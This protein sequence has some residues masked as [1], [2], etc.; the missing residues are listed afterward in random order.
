NTTGDFVAVLN[1]ATLTAAGTD[2]LIHSSSAAYNVLSGTA[3]TTA[4]RFFFDV[5]GMGGTTGTRPSTATLAGPLL[6]SNNDRF[7][8]AAAFLMTNAGGATPSE[9]VALRQAAGADPFVPFLGF[10]GSV[11]HLGFDPVG[12][13]GVAG[14][15]NLAQVNPNT[16]LRLTGPLA[17]IDTQGQGPWLIDRFVLARC[18]SAFECSGVGTAGLETFTTAPLITLNGT[19]VEGGVLVPHVL[20]QAMFDLAGTRTTAET[21]PDALGLTVG[22]DQPLRHAG[23]LFQGQ[24]TKITVG[25]VLRIDTALLAAT[26][27][28]VNLLNHSDLTV[29]H[30]ALDLVNQAKLAVN[31]PL[32]AVFRL[33]ASKLTILQGS[34]ANVS[35]SFMRVV[36]NLFALSGGSTLTINDGA[37]VTVSNG[38]VFRLTA[39]S[40]GLFGSGTNL[41]HILAT[42][43]GGSIVSIAG[44]PV[45]FLHDAQASQV[46][47]A[48]GFVPFSGL[49]GSNTVSVDSG[50][51]VL[52]VDGTTAQIILGDFV[53]VTHLNIVNIVKNPNLHLG[54][55]ETLDPQLANLTGLGE[56]G[57][58]ATLVKVQN[59]SNVTQDAGGNLVLVPAGANVTLGG[60][61]LEVSDSTVQAGN[62]VVRVDGVLSAGGLLRFDPASATATTM[63]EINGTVSLTGPLF[64]D[65][66]GTFDISGDFAKVLGTLTTSTSAA[67]LDFDRSSVVV[68]QSMINLA[69]V[70]TAS[71]PDEGIIVGTDRPL[72]HAGVLFQATDANATVGQVVRIDTALLEAT[73]PVVDLLRSNV[74]VQGNALDL[75]DKARLTAGTVQA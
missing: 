9:M 70:N 45:M 6:D 3:P 32:D 57:G 31:V 48:F 69:G 11:V 58:G 49:G 65:V 16:Q 7:N 44:I 39:G 19:P 66:R 1:G 15:G 4:S 30:H 24:D 38:G 60:L 17:F 61:L 33:D 25:E 56:F 72:R 2:A 27:P 8:I 41:L 21:D 12:L 35:N 40:L 10:Y 29:Q 26:A 62:A 20:N 36:G 47:V 22:T 51:A 37:L 59:K 53:A 68:G 46:L 43:G 23:V 75:V 67:L 64:T 55:G 14:A 50:A 18:G 28:V 71:D 42:P 73:K 54:A 34:L 5:F 52:V 74:N 63:A 13:V